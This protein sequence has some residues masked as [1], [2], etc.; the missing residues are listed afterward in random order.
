M[1]AKFESG[2]APAHSKTLRVNA[3]TQAEYYSCSQRAA[4]VFYRADPAEV[5]TELEEIVQLV[6]AAV[7]RRVIG[8]GANGAC[9]KRD[10]VQFT[11]VKALAQE[12]KFLPLE[13]H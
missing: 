5:G 1:I 8:D 3:S 6:E 2:G 12:P 7:P 11:N 4:F 9:G 13:S 10:K